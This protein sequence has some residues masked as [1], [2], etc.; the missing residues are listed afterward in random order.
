LSRCA[1]SVLHAASTRPD[2]IGRPA[3]WSVA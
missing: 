3:A 1:T 2:P